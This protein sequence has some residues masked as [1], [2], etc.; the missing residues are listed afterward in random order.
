MS[1]K[2]RLSHL[3]DQEVRELR[4]ALEQDKIAKQVQDDSSI[5]EGHYSP[6]GGIIESYARRKRSESRTKNIQQ[7]ASEIAAATGLRT[8]A[9]GSKIAIATS[10]HE[11]EQAPARLKES[12]QLEKVKHK[13]IKKRTKIATKKKASPEALDG[14]VQEKYKTNQTIRLEKKKAKIE[15]NKAKALGEHEVEVDFRKKMNTLTTITHYRH[16]Q[17]D[18]FDEVR[19]RLITLLEEV[20]RIENSNMEAHLKGAIISQMK[21]AIEAYQ[22]V[23]DVH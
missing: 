10:A 8:T 18:A 22:E 3:T 16:L 15:V 14:M 13:N 7:Q 21:Q 9:N 2:K 6:G 1:L 20:H 12:R 19:G 5:L 11:L 17:F 23:F 4:L